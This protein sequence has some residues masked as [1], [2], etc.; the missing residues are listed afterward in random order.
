MPENP[1]Q[2]Q[3][4]AAELQQLQ[5]L[6]QMAQSGDPN[7]LPQIVQGLEQMI[8]AQQKEMQELQGA[9]GQGAMP[10]PKASFKEKLGA[11]MQKAQVAKQGGQP[12]EGG[13]Q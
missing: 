3:E 10:Q 8:A 9:D 11:A 6:L 13:G 12:P 7:A 2:M 5:Q 4:E 1:N